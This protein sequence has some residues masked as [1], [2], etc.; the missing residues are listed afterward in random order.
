LPAPRAGAGCGLA[1]RDDG[2]HRHILDA[3]KAAPSDGSARNDNEAAEGA[4]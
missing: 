4:H 3:I 2:I 1:W